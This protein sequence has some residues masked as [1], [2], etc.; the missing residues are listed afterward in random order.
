MN[1]NITHKNHSQVYNRDKKVSRDLLRGP[2]ANSK[3][4]TRP[5]PDA[6]PSI[7]EVERESYNHFMTFD[8][9]SIN[10]SIIIYV[11]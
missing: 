2:K 8:R 10:P 7:L 4:D 11:K 6:I 5:I 9:S 3:E 1:T